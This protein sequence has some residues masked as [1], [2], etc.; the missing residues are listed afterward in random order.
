MWNDLNSREL[1]WLIQVI[2]VVRIQIVRIFFTTF[3][4][5]D[6]LFVYISKKYPDTNEKLLLFQKICANIYLNHH[7]QKQLL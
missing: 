5:S 7:L 4:L 1:K 2:P 6:F 3:S